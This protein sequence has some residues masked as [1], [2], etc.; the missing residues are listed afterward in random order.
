MKRDWALFPGLMV[1]NVSWQFK[2]QEVA[3]LLWTLMCHKQATLETP[4]PNFSHIW[5]T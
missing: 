5:S 4:Q 2:L 1:N 3:L